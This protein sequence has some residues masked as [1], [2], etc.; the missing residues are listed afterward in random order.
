MGGLTK[1][2]LKDPSK[3]NIKFV[4]DILVGMK[5]AKSFRFY[6][7]AD[8]ELEYKCFVDGEGTFPDDQFPKNQIGRA[9]V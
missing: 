5:L 6:S 2:H 1:I 9:H 8:V 7:E 4:N 3:E